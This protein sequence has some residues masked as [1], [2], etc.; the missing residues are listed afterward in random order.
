MAQDREIGR[1][2]ML[3]YLDRRLR[4]VESRLE[5]VDPDST[6]AEFLRGHQGEIKGMM[7]WIKASSVSLADWYQMGDRDWQEIIKAGEQKLTGGEAGVRGNWWHCNFDPE[8]AMILTD[9]Q[10]LLS[11]KLRREVTREDVVQHALRAFQSLLK[12]KPSARIKV[13]DGWKVEKF[14][15]DELL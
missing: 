11:H 3:T 13:Q 6:D 4:D 5:K 10:I 1:D 7:A 9:M 15:L 12:H 14:S 2:T 8:A